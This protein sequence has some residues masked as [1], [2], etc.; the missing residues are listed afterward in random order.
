MRSNQGY[1]RFSFT[2]RSLLGAAGALLALGALAGCGGSGS[3]STPLNNNPVTSAPR[4]TNNLQFTLSAD[5]TVYARNTPANI[6][7]AVKNVST[8]PISVTYTTDGPD[9]VQIAQGGT[10]AWSAQNGSGNTAQVL[11]FAA[12]E[13]K[14]FTETWN[15]MNLQTG[16]QAKSGTYNVDAQLRA[17]QING[18]TVSAQV[19]RDL[20]ANTIQITIQ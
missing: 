8:S 9:F 3:S 10:A 6:T 1:T 12:G 15:Q 20:S 19:S 4:T 17:T 11:T 2:R 5:R 13:T 7:F 16:A 14:T 18:V